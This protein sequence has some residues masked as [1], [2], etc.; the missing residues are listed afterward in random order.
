MSEQNKATKS[1]MDGVKTAT[2][3]QKERDRIR[4]DDTPPKT[5]PTAKPHFLEESFPWDTKKR[6][7]ELPKV[8]EYE[9]K[10]YQI[11]KETL[12][13]FLPFAKKLYPHHVESLNA[14]IKE[15]ESQTGKKR[16]E[17]G[18]SRDYAITPKGFLNLP[19]KF[20]YN[21]KLEGSGRAKATFFKSKNQIIVE[22]IK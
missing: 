2:E 5:I 18:E 12:V 13:G 14:K 1:S 20:L 3:R 4:D 21:E 8:F 10:E 17:E 22:L 6:M 16:P 7:P 19:I 11:R 15:L 9:G